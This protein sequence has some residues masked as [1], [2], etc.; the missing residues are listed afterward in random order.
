MIHTSNYKPVIIPI[1]DN[2]DR[3]EIDRLQDLSATVALNRTKIKEIGRDATV[4]WRKSIPTVNV[5]LKQL[6][7]GS[8]QFWNDLANKAQSNT[9]ITLNDFKTSM[10]D[11]LGYKTD[12][13]LSVLGTVMYPKLRTSGFSFNIGSPDA[14]AE[15]SFTLVGEDELFWQNNNKYVIFFK[16]TCPTTNATWTVE[17]GASGQ[18]NYPY[19]VNDPDLSGNNYF[20]RIMRVRAGVTTEM[21]YTTNYTYVSG[22]HIITLKDVQVG[23]IYKFWYT[24]TT[25]ISAGSTFTQND[26]DMIALPAENCSI[27]LTSGQ[28]VYRLQ[29]V[30]VDVTFD[31]TDLKEIGNTEVV[32][33]GIK[34]K[35]VKVT[36]GR[37]L[38][39]MTI[40]E[41]LRNKVGSSWGKLNPRQFV[42]GLKL[43]V[44][45]YT[46]SAK[47]AFNLG[48]SFGNLGP[49][50]LDA[51]VPLDDYAKRGVQLEGEE[52][53]ITTV[54]GS[55]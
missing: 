15:R 35:T 55:M 1:N 9:V 51:G 17:I 19:P 37:V 52:G 5:S 25:Y 23:D 46:T 20:H 3:N 43:Y 41:I 4:G 21:V 45:M 13:S 31:R 53:I 27:Y 36:L 10:S 42:D 12:D 28:Y 40:E 18:L 33:R 48:Y 32:S 22:T 38:E 2:T 8:I 16:K 14:L 30:A 34:S 47:T 39:T 7:N 24:A 6:E 29:S 11:I 50:N 44:K 49:V 26:S 54:E